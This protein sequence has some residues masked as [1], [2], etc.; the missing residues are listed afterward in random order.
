LCLRSEIA[1][2]KEYQRKYQQ[3][4]LHRFKRLP[5]LRAGSINVWLKLESP[6]FPSAG[7]QPSS[8]IQEEGDFE[9]GQILHLKS[10]NHKS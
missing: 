1:G 9:I 4:F 2:E 7:Q 6:L 5:R 8:V 10:R 3:Q